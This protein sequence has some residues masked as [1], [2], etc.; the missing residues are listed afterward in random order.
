MICVPLRYSHGQK[1]VLVWVVDNSEN[2]KFVGMDTEKEI[3]NENMG[4]NVENRLIWVN[5]D[6]IY[7]NFTVPQILLKHKILFYFVNLINNK[8]TKH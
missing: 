2:G 5:V 8:T 7:A 1:K 6:S 4:K 3:I